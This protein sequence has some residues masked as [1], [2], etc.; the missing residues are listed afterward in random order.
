MNF[1]RRIF[2]HQTLNETFGLIK[3]A[4]IAGERC[5]MNHENGGT[6][7]S[8]NVAAIARIGDIRIEISGSNYRRITLL[9]G[10]HAGA[11]T[12]PDPTGAHV[13]K[14]IEY[15]DGRR[16]PGGPEFPREAFA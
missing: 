2:P 5:P 7:K 8:M 4:A 16:R 10:P 14:V 6:L 13:W 11:A 1:G 15:R 9:T 12:A 3:A